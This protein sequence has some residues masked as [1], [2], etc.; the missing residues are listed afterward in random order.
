MAKSKKVAYF[1]MEIGLESDIPTYSGGL[2]ILAGDTLKSAA[3]LGLPLA[4]VSLIYHKGYVKQKLNEVGS[5]CEEPASWNVSSKFEPLPNEVSLKFEGRNVKIK[6]WKYSIKG[7]S[8]H[9]VPIY[10]LDTDIEGNAEI[11]KKATHYLYNGDDYFRLLQEAILGIGGVRMLKSLGYD[12]ETYHMNEGHASLLTLELLRERGWNN[13]NVKKSCTFTTH[14][15][16]A[17]H[18]SFDYHLVERTLRQAIPGHVRDIAGKDMFNMTLLALNM[19]RYTN[20]V[21]KK[22]AEVSKGLFPNFNIDYITN[23]VH[24]YTWT[25]KSFQKLYDEHIPGWRSDPKLLEHASEIPNEKIWAAHEEAKKELLKRTPGFDHNLLTIGYA[26]R[27]VHYKRMGLIFS[28]LERLI[29]IGQGKLQLLYAGKAHPNN[30]EGKETIQ[31]I[32]QLSKKL[33]GKIKLVF[34]EDYDM[35]LGHHLT[36]GCDIWL[37]HPIVPLE[38]CGTSGMKSCHNGVPHFSTL[39]GWWPEGYEEDVTGWAIGNTDGSDD[40]KDTK[41]FYDKLENKIMPLYYNNREKWIEMMKKVISIN[42]PKF[43]SHR[44]AKEYAQKAY[45]LE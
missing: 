32:V 12:A 19:S 4:G 7:Q 11:D 38:A 45:S 27:A 42:A 16:V 23:G 36:S 22:H 29:R 5:Q 40:A 31:H 15:P 25:F 43:N 1:S 20:A 44:M 14:S 26:R 41:S 21:S 17:G 30:Y 13:E 37:N 24:P 35:E 2:G 39:D 9:E 33:E 34:L 8:G 18:D 6:S 3:D 10:F 28:D